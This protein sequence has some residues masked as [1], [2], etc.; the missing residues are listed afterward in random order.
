MIVFPKLPGAKLI[1]QTRFRVVRGQPVGLLA[2][3][4]LTKAFTCI[5]DIDIR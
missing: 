4:S 5:H 1:E 3:K 2:T